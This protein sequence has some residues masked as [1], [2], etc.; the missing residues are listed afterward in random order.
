MEEALTELCYFCEDTA[1]KS[2][3]RAEDSATELPTTATSVDMADFKSIDSNA[4][5]L[6]NL[7]GAPDAVDCIDC[8]GNTSPA[9]PA[10]CFADVSCAAV[11]AGEGVCSGSDPPEGPQGR[12]IAQAF[13]SMLDG[14]RGIIGKR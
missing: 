12:S 10:D 4:S 6:Q 5:S 2:H 9:A 11:G 8:S 1:R 7:Y 14:D 13:D 3:R